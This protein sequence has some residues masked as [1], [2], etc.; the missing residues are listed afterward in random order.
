MSLRVAFTPAAEVERRS[1]A[2]ERRKAFDRG[3]EAIACNPYGCG[4]SQVGGDPDRRDATVSN[5]AFIT[6]LVSQG[7]LTVTVVKIVALP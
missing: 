4:S 5:V 1:L 2:G 7:V 3:M 6:Y